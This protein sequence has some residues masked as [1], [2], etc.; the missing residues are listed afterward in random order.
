M[1]AISIPMS[2]FLWSIGR[3]RFH[4]LVLVASSGFHSR[5][6]SPTKWM[7]ELVCGWYGIWVKG[8]LGGSQFV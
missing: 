7:R 8:G 6:L 2:I 1:M 5:V 3:W 4:E